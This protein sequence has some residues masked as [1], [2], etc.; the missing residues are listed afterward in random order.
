VSDPKPLG[1]QAIDALEIE[2]VFLV[3]VTS[4]VNRDFNQTD[5]SFSELHAMQRYLVESQVL[6]Q[7]RAPQDAPD[8]NFLIIRYFFRGDVVLAK[9]SYQITGEE[10]P[11]ESR[12]ASLNFVFALDYRCEIAAEPSS[13]MLGAFSRNVVYHAWPYWRA[14]THAECVRLRIPPITVPMMKAAGSPPGK[15]LQQMTP[16]NSGTPVE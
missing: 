14:A 6:K 11:E 2:D 15:K 5:H 1:A 3:E 7:L 8:K 13:D 10:I 16:A 4:S 12:L 9:P